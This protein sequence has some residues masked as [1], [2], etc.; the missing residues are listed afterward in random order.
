MKFLIDSFTYRGNTWV[1]DVAGVFLE[2][3]C[4]AAFAAILW[5]MS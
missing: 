2:F 1:H 4:L 3:S 5:S